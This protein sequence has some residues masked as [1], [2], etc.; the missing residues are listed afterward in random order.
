MSKL[1]LHRDDARRFLMRS[2]KHYDVIIGDLFHPDMVGRGAL[3]SVEQ[4]RRA[5][6]R[7]NE[8]GLFVQWLAF[9]QF[10]TR[11]L[12][13][14]LRSFAEVF[15]HNAVFIDGYRLGLVGFA[16]QNL[17]ASA[18]MTAAPAKAL[19]GHEGGW[20][21][22]GRYWGDVSQLLGGAMRGPLQGEWTPVIEF[23]LPSM[24]YAENTLPELL[25]WLIERRIGLAEAERY[26]SIDASQVMPFKRSWASSELN[27]RAQLLS[28]QGKA[29]SERLQALAYRA[30][31]D[32][33]W[34]AFGL[35]DAMFASLDHGLPDGLTYEQALQ[36]ILHIRPDHE[37]ALKAMFMLLEER[38]D[39][40]AAAKYR[41]RL[42]RVSP[43]A[44][45]S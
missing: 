39:G 2:E 22:L 35:A 28:L 9:N 30:N 5:K 24:R 23:S 7:L 8:Q 17:S 13:V 15:A 12:Q 32:G 18:L 31:P 6:K 27:T 36:K 40:N 3:L 19:W 44:R 34:A 29:G 11:S 20:T 21:W 38:G 26:W 4:F 25:Q 45:V 33:R 14:V 10:D 42:F 41:D 43:Y 16:N 37:G 1:D